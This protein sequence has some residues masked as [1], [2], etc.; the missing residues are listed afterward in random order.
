MP[1][2]SFVRQSERPE[3]Q[4]SY[5]DDDDGYDPHENEEGDF[6]AREYR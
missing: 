6:K 2:V 3:D 4:R 5:S 1:L